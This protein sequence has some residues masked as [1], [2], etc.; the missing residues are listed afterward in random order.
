MAGFLEG[1][2]RTIGGL[3]AG[4]LDARM[5]IQAKH[6]SMLQSI[7][8]KR[9][10]NRAVASGAFTQMALG[11]GPIVLDNLHDDGQEQIAA[12]RGLLADPRFQDNRAELKFAA[13]LMENSATN[14][15]GG[16]ILNSIVTQQQQQ[17]TAIRREAADAKALAGRQGITDAAALEKATILQVNK[18][19]DV[20]LAMRDDAVRELG[21]IAGQIP[22][23]TGAL[24]ILASGSTTDA[25]ASIFQFMQT[26]EPGGIV[27]EGEQQMV[28]GTGGLSNQLANLINQ[29]EGKGLTGPTRKA[30][31][32]TMIKII[33]PRIE[34][35]QTRQQQL[36]DAA[37]LAGLQG[38]NVPLAA[39]NF[40][41][42][43]IPQ[44][45]QQL[46]DGSIPAGEVDQS[47]FVNAP[48]P[49]E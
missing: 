24:D 19:R 48:Q 46:I 49:G 38:S 27:R 45:P 31:A 32:R 6:Q 21:P 23:F 3:Q 14:A 12:G 42:F 7:L 11:H 44:I 10:E 36:R 30:L 18:N 29:A 25:I 17:D 41:D 28:R 4:I 2:G 34:A 39:G 20:A 22:E 26:I 9:D 5:S 15:L 47:R 40:G 13:R 35:A 1:I 33:K 16:N 37:G 8:L 43:N